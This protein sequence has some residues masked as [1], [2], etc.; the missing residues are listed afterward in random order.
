MSIEVRALDGKSELAAAALAFRASM[1]GLPRLASID[2]ELLDRLFEPNRAWG[3]FE[4]GQLVGTT[5]SYSG[6]IRV[7]GGSWLPQ[8][9]VTHFGVFPTHVRRGIGRA[10]MLGQLRAAREAGEL[11]ATLRATEATIYGNFGYGVANETVGYE[12]DRAKTRLRSE[13]VSAGT[14]RLISDNATWPI[15]MRI[16]ERQPAPRPGTISR[17]Q[18]WWD[19]AIARQAF[20]AEP[21]YVAV[22]GDAGH[23]TGYVRYR[24]LFNEPWVASSARTVIVDD[25]VAHTDE[26]YVVLIGYLLSLDIA[27]RILLPVWPVDDPLPHMLTNRRGAQLTGIRDETW[28]RMLDTEAAL[29]LRSYGMADTVVLEVVD[30]EIPENS[31]RLAIG[32][33]CVEPSRATPHA[34]TSVA[35]LSAAYLGGT[36]WWQLAAA[37]RVEISDQRHLI[38]LDHLFAV[39]RSPFSGT[40]F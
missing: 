19:G 36:R 37:G 23:E 2:D 22:C 40:M 39:D 11:V 1:I 31:V 27:H 8:A 20:A 25:L 7:P 15:Q 6:R 4:N 13:F 3:A 38:S 29:R 10:L 21:V 28:L 5:N 14:L 30:T 35:A 9:A 12:I 32:T 26:A 16:Y 33:D 18:R 34:V 24:P 17:P